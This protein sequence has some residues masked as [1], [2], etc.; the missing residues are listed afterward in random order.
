MGTFIDEWPLHPP[1]FQA[2]KK[3]LRAPNIWK[4]WNLR[5]PRKSKSHSKP[6]CR[7]FQASPF[8]S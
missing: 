1:S 6:V 3:V 5:E 7:G 4:D 2:L 8:G